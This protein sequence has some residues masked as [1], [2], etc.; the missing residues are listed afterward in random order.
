M[1]LTF[2]MDSANGPLS[3]RPGSHSYCTTGT[4]PC[5]SIISRNTAGQACQSI[6]TETRLMTTTPVNGD[7]FGADLEAHEIF[8]ND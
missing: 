5:R 2:V 1:S 4:S 8:P 6:S 7:T 3:S